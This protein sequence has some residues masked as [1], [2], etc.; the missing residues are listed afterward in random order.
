MLFRSLIN[1]PLI[2]C[3]SVMVVINSMIENQDTLKI[4]N[5]ILNSSTGLIIGMISNFKIYERITTYRN[6]Y[7]KYNKLSNF[8]D[9]KL[10]NEM[11]LINID[12]I[13]NVVNE[14][15]NIGEQQDFDYPTKIRR[16]IKKEYQ[17]KLSLPLSLQVDLVECNKNCCN[18][19]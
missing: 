10:T 18:N 13:E 12:F 2:V 8:I 6:L 17:D 14:Y 5:I 11:E 15:N 9:S 1:I 3:N 16:R 19:A 4:L 7:I